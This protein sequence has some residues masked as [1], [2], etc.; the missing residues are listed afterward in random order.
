MSNVIAADI[1]L[2]GHG[3]N[4]APAGPVPD[5]VCGDCDRNPAHDYAITDE[6]GRAWIRRAVQ[7]ESFAK[8][9]ETELEKLRAAPKPTACPTIVVGNGFAEQCSLPAGHDGDHMWDGC[10]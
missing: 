7:A 1:V 4:K 6:T 8:A 5:V 2:S 10:Y 9:I 3:K